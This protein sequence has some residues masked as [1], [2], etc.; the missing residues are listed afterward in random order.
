MTAN[1][2]PTPHDQH[3]FDAQWW[4]Q[5]YRSA[6]ALPTGRPSAQLVAEVAGLNPGTVLDAGS[7]TGADAVWLAEQGW[8]VTAVDVSPTAVQQARELAGQH[9]TTA[10]A[11]IAWF[12]ADLTIWVPPQ[13]YDLVVSQYV[14]PDLPF[15]AFVQRLARAVAPGGTLLVVGHDHADQH[16]AAHAPQ[17]A[18]IGTAAV[19]DALDP[20]RW[21]V[22]VAESRTREVPRGATRFTIADL[23]V[24][25]RR[26]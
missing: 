18:S 17:P 22:V 12:V 2:H 14:H 9:A 15:E 8:T 4:E 20:G 7:G 11:R 10:A 24:R 1:R 25:A 19:V 21:E 13:Q 6:T 16:S 5:H 23:V 3:D 26:R